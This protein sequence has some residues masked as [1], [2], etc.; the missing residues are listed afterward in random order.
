MTLLSYSFLFHFKFKRR[1][2]RENLPRE[3]VIGCQGVKLF[4]LKDVNIPLVT[5][6]TIPIVTISVF[7]FCHNLIFFK[8]LS[9][10]EYLIFFTIHF[11][12][13]ITI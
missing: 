3:H 11:Y 2:N 9:Q 5:T 4:L 1:E 8:F 13:L 7:E 12:S 10:V 6:V